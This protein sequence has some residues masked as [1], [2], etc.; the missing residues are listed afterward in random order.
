MQFCHKAT[1]RTT[2]S[3]CSF[4]TWSIFNFGKQY[5]CPSCFWLGCSPFRPNYIPLS[6]G[7]IYLIS[8]FRL[9]V[10]SLWSHGGCTDHDNYSVLLIYLPFIPAVSAS[11]HMKQIASYKE[12]DLVLGK[13][14]C[15]MAFRPANVEPF[16]DRVESLFSPTLWSCLSSTKNTYAV[17]KWFDA[18]TGYI[19]NLCSPVVLITIT[20]VC[21]TLKFV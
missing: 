20:S 11:A 17:C 3:H 16:M 12:G 4:W 19:L 15:A 6:F 8:V 10:F 21:K 18:S 13:N 5:Q 14:T 1:K 7:F 2:G 9:S